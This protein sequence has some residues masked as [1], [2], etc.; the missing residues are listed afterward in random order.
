MQSLQIC[1]GLLRG[2]SLCQRAVAFR[3]FLPAAMRSDAH[4]Y[5]VCCCC[6]SRLNACFCWSAC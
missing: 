3:G 5:G 1:T 6:N 2:D 4:L